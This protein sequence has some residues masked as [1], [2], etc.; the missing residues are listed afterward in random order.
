MPQYEFHVG[1]KVTIGPPYD[2]LPVILSMQRHVH[3]AASEITGDGGTFVQVRLD[4]AGQDNAFQ[5]VPID[6]VHYGWKD[7]SGRWL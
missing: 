1:D 6:Q 4:S 5:M 3:V 7:R 2:D